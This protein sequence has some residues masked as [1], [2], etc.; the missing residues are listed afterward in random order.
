MQADVKNSKTGETETL[1]LCK[2]ALGYSYVGLDP[3]LSLIWDSIRDLIKKPSK[4]MIDC[5]K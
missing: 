2:A 5:Q 4:E 1:S 3:E